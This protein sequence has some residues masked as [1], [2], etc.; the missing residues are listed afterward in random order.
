MYQLNI[1]FSFRS[2]KQVLFCFVLIYCMFSLYFLKVLFI[3]YNYNHGIYLAVTFEF[4]SISLNSNSHVYHYSIYILFVSSMGGNLCP[5]NLSQ[6]PVLESVLSE[7]S[8]ATT[9]HLPGIVRS[10]SSDS[11][12]SEDSNDESDCKLPD[13]VP[14]PIQLLDRNSGLTTSLLSFLKDMN[15]P[16]KNSIVSP[17]SLFGQVCRK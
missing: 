17:A 9:L 14:I 15:N 1:K 4:I 12:D 5:Q 10:L 7:S 3:G 2:L 13:L 11:E 16:S 8:K 6:T